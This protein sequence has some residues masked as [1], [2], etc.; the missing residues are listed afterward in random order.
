MN[1]ALWHWLVLTV[2]RKVCRDPYRSFD[3]TRYINTV[4]YSPF[5]KK[6]RKLYNS[7]LHIDAFWRLCSR[8]LFK[9]EGEITYQEQFLLLPQLYQFYP[10][11]MLSFIEMFYVLFVSSV[12][13][14]AGCQSRG[15]EFQS[16]LGQLSFRR[17]TKVNATC[18]CRLPPMG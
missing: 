18:V 5:F 4:Q 16:R 8:R 1:V 7:F 14:D 6:E 9:T 15:C 3:N 12:G 11:T 17:L 2:E 10:R 13:S